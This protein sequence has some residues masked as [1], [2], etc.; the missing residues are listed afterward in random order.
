MWV[1]LQSTDKLVVILFRTL[2][3]IGKGY[4]L[5]YFMTKHAMTFNP[6]VFKKLLYLFHTN[7]AGHGY[8]I[9]LLSVRLVNKTLH[10]KKP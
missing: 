7:F 6:I 3:Y 5:V 2:Y 8:F 9:G 4:I 10:A 1:S